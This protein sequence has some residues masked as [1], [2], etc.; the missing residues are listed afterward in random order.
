MR[1]PAVFIALAIVILIPFLIWGEWFESMFTGDGLRLWL[2]GWGRSWGWLLALLLLVGDLFLPVPGT[3]VMSG[4]GYVYGTLAGGAVAA[5]GSFLSGSLAYWLCRKCGG[6]MAARLMGADGLAKGE[7]L[8]GGS[9][10]GFLVALSR[11]LPL[12]PEVVACM[13]GLTKM[14]AGRFHLALACGSL[15]MGFVF[16]GI[17]AAGK[18]APGAAMGLSILIPALLY[19]VA[20]FIMKRRQAAG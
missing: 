19:G 9:S 18:D 5:A 14:P 6:R 3:A 12:L 20:L 16:A 1:L 4:L 2:E 17:G 10:G 7:H 15:P 11:C 8:F 13:A